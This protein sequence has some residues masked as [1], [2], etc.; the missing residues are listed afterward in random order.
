MKNRALEQDKKNRA[1]QASQAV[2]NTN[3]MPR[4]KWE[5]PNS[6]SSRGKPNDDMYMNPF[7]THSDSFHAQKL[8]NLPKQRKQWGGPKAKN[9]FDYNIDNED[10]F[11]E[12]LGFK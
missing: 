7:E 3:E 6:A 11:L 5:A 8:Q 9:T 4:R 1:K 12:D 2:K 10:N